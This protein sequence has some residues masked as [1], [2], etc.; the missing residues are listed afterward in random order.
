[1]SNFNTTAPFAPSALGRDDFRVD[2]SFSAASD[3]VVLADKICNGLEDLRIQFSAVH[4]LPIFTDMGETLA[5]VIETSNS[6]RVDG[7]SVWKMKDLQS[8][9]T[10]NFAVNSTQYQRMRTTGH[11]GCRIPTVDHV[12][13]A[14]AVLRVGIWREGV[15]HKQE[16]ELREEV[17]KANGDT[18]HKGIQFIASTIS[19]MK[20]SLWLGEY[21]HAAGI[22]E[23]VQSEIDRV[24]RVSKDTQD[25][26][27]MWDDVRTFER[28][29]DGKIQTMTCL[30]PRPPLPI[31][32]GEDPKSLSPTFGSGS[33]DEGDS[34][35]DESSEIPAQEDAT[36]NPPATGGHS[37]SG[38]ADDD[39]LHKLV[40]PLTAFESASS[41]DRLSPQRLYEEAEEIGARLF[42]QRLCERLC[43]RYPDLQRSGAQ[44]L[45][46]LMETHGEA[47]EVLKGTVKTSKGKELYC[48][49]LVDKSKGSKH[50]TLKLPGNGLL[51]SAIQLGLDLAELD[52][53]YAVHKDKSSCP[54]IISE[55]GNWLKMEKKVIGFT[56]CGTAECP[57]FNKVF[58]RRSVRPTSLCD[59]WTS[60]EEASDE[61]TCVVLP[62][63]EYE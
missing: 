60:A 6:H 59:S 42:N 51:R 17:L 21:S 45:N 22:L 12:V 10:T 39:L 28:V 55:L 46:E 31:L 35:S 8:Q 49:L 34:S 36:A 19:Q 53:W 47:L 38:E 37:S 48:L 3:L 13:Y 23:I 18:I 56:D 52:Y 57:R 41:P 32:T 4:G 54:Q 15:Q 27:A 7:S 16:Q 14:N 63:D 5:N 61:E 2:G 33:V 40:I 24:E 11:R 30:R 26:Q 9:R 50:E 43:E 44:L 58:A 25:I 29:T 1:M 62:S 20:Q